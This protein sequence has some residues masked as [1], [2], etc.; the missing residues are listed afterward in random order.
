M[1]KDV[2]PIEV[3]LKQE[4]S[5]DDPFEGLNNRAAMEVATELELQEKSHSREFVIMETVKVLKEEE[6]EKDHSADEDPLDPPAQENESEQMLVDHKTKPVCEKC[7]KDFAHI[8]T[9]KK[10]ITRCGQKGVFT[11]DWPGCGKT[12]LRGAQRHQRIHLGGR[13]HKC[14]EAGCDKAYGRKDLLDRHML[15]HSMVNSPRNVYSCDWP[16]CGKMFID[17]N[18]ERR[19]KMVHTG[20]RPFRCPGEG[21]DKAFG[22]K[23][24]LD[25]HLLT[26]STEKPYKCLVP[27]C[28]KL[29]SQKFSFDRHKLL[30]TGEKPY[31]CIELGCDKAF[32]YWKQ[33]KTHQERHH[34]IKEGAVKEE[35]LILNEAFKEKAVTGK[36]VACGEMC[37]KEKEIIKQETFFDD[38]EELVIKEESFIKEEIVIEEAAMEEEVIGT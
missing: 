20:E 28:G 3:R 13:P 4:M 38:G 5:E 17:R 14:P 24:A 9:L 16:G 12:L 25:K 37:I 11:C 23:S 7:G 19:H 33:I 1:S 32:K 34:G 10:H 30:H 18:W 6:R 22:R 35:V 21:C 36:N 31:K 15:T 2:S 8:S 26:H 27:H 29:F